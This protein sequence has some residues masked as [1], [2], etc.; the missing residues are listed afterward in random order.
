MITEE[1]QIIGHP[2]VVDFEGEASGDVDSEVEEGGDTVEGATL[3]DQTLTGEE[4]STIV[5]HF[6]K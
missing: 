2:E 6:Q 5:L 4:A 3:G 1:K